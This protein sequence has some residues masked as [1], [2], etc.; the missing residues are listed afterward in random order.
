MPRS[1]R[2]CGEWTNAPVYPGCGR[3]QSS[4]PSAV[5]RATHQAAPN[6]GLGLINGPIH[7]Q[8]GALT[9]MLHSRFRELHI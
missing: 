4:C 9:A 6:P 5:K 3:K 2:I 7:E 1:A 8:V